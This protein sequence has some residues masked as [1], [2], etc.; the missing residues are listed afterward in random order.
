MRWVNFIAARD[1]QVIASPWERARCWTVVHPRIGGTGWGSGVAIIYEMR[2]W[3][4]GSRMESDG[5]GETTG[6]G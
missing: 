2:D 4:R 6:H 1:N 3:R 5:D